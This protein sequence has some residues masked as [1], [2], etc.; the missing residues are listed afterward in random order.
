M[1][2][3]RRKTLPP[4]RGQIDHEEEM[5]RFRQ[6]L[7]KVYRIV[8]PYAPDE[9]KYVEAL[10]RMPGDPYLTVRYGQF[11]LK[12]GRLGEAKGLYEKT[13]EERPYDMAIR[14]ALA[15]VL[16]LGGMRAEAIKVLMSDEAAYP[17]DRKRALSALGVH[18]VQSGRIAEATQVYKE[19]G[20]LDPDNLDVLINLAAANQH[21]GADEGG[22]ASA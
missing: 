9:T 1:T 6:S 21:A 5:E 14:V 13:L 16:A 12:K 7:F 2:M 15:K 22:Q 17:Y 10:D 19:L 8:K 20:D 18:Y 4:F 3:Y 11:L